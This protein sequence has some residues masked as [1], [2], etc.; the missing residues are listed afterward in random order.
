MNVFK[1][2]NKEILPL[3]INSKLVKPTIINPIKILYKLTNAIVNYIDKLSL[4]I[5]IILPICMIIFHDMYNIY[6]L[7]I[8]EILFHDTYEIIDIFYLAYYLFSIIQI[9]IFINIYKK[10][11][12]QLIR[13]YNNTYIEIYIITILMYYIILIFTLDL[14]DILYDTI[15]FLKIVNHVISISWLYLFFY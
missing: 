5:I 3:H 8:N 4:E 7:I 2:K 9:I 11:K 15:E 6:D 10:C 13:T 14:H 12:T 1:R